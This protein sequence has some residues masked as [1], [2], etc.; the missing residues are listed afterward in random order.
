MCQCCVVL[1]RRPTLCPRQ[2]L[3]ALHGLKCFIMQAA[4]MRQDATMQSQNACIAATHC[5]HFRHHYAPS[6]TPI[7]C[8]ASHDSKHTVHAR[9][10]ASSGQALQQ[11]TQ[12][13]VHCTFQHIRL[14]SLRTFLPTLWRSIGH[15]QINHSTVCTCHMCIC[16]CNTD[17]GGTCTWQVLH[18]RMFVRLPP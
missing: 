4:A 12:A 17:P 8:G 11:P 7:S 9:R 1:R 14:A 2:T 5:S 3:C 6:A 10:A 18:G 15:F 13:T 16:A